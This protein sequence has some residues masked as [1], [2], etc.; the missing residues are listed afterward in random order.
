MKGIRCRIRKGKEKGK[1][2]M[3]GYTRI[4]EG[5]AT[6]GRRTRYEDMLRKMNSDEEE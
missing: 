3:G 5:K 1:T 2:L 6:W 4:L